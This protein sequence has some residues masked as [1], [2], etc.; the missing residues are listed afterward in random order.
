MVGC[1]RYVGG[2]SVV[3]YA[4]GSGVLTMV[5]CTRG[6]RLRVAPSATQQRGVGPDCQCRDDRKYN[7]SKHVMLA[8]HDGNMDA[9]DTPRAK[10]QNEVSLRSLA[11]LR[12]YTW[13]ISPSDAENPA[14]RLTTSR[15]VDYLL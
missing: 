13:G 15:P 9:N 5:G 6:S 11:S 10:S 1:A 2:L 14:A 7:C 3:R 8:L 4:R 12:G